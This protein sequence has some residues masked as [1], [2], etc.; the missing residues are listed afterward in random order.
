MTAQS[1]PLILVLERDQAVAASLVF[2]L[3]LE[4]FDVE[5]RA[6]P[7]TLERVADTLPDCLLVDADHPAVS[8][9]GLLSLIR[10]K[11][12]VGPTIFTATNPKRRLSAEIRASGASLLEKPWTGD[13]VIAEIRHAL[14]R[15]RPA[16]VV[17]S[18]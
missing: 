14:L 3:R 1:R 18:A 8:P 12:Y 17:A 5:V 13:G 2:A 15:H 9:I 16:V 11:G 10:A 4:G 7:G 6:D